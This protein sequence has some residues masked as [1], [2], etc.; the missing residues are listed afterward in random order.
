[1]QSRPPP[2]QRE[3]DGG[4]DSLLAA[5]EGRRVGGLFNFIALFCARP[6]L[7]HSG[8]GLV[9]STCPLS[10]VKRIWRT[11]LRRAGFLRL[12]KRDT[13]LCVGSPQRLATTPSTVNN[14]IEASGNA[15][16]G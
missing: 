9:H 6:L 11:G 16:A 2:S 10:E 15:E 4:L 3:N 7:A 12:F 14:D 8:H 5:G 13:D 1:M